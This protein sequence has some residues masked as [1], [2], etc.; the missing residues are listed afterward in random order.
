[1][2]T[3]Q[4]IPTLAVKLVWRGDELPKL[5]DQS[6]LQSGLPFVYIGLV[7]LGVLLALTFGTRVWRRLHGT[8]P[9]L[10]RIVTPRRG[11]APE[12]A[13]NPAAVFRRIAG[14]LGL[15]RADQKLLTK[16]SAAQGLPSPLTLLFSPATLNHHAAVHTADMLPARRDQVLDRIAAVEQQLFG[17]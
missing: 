15:A 16:I 8:G 4:H 3:P 9:A 1:M 14:Q 5:S 2:M 13:G 11:A 12:S 6:P 10:Q 7:V 17:G